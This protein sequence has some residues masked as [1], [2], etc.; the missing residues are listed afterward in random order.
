MRF[1]DLN[2]HPLLLNTI[3]Q[4]GYLM[5]TP[6]Q[7]R[8]I[9]EVLK[10]R[11]LLACA[12]TGTG[13]TAAFA[14]PILHRLLQHPRK[15]HLPRVLVLAPTRELATQIIESFALYG[16]G[17]GLSG[18]VIFGG[19]S[20]G[21]QIRALQEGIDVL[22]AAPG[23]L[24]DLMD[25][26]YVK[27]SNIE[28]FVLDEADRM[29]DMGFIK[30]IKR[31]LAV[32]PPKRQNLLF[33]ATMPAEIRE[34]TKRLLN[35]PIHIAVTPVASTVDR[36]D[37]RVYFVAKARKTDLL[38]HV[39]TDR[40]ADRVIVFTRTKHGANRLS[41]KLQKMLINAEAIHGDKSQNA[42]QKS[43]L[44]FK[45][46]DTR[47]LV[48]T[49]VAARGIDVTG[50]SHVVNF[51][52]P[53]EPESYVHR[54]GRTARA[55]ASGLALSFCDQDEQPLLRN[56]ESLIKT[57]VPV[58]HSH[59]FVEVKQSLCNKKRNAKKRST[60]HYNSKPQYA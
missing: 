39:L 49:D 43:L 20:Q 55:G 11:D 24:L 2:L 38:A 52:L 23:R 33:S 27:L 13:K 14:L 59:P 7:A 6:I 25:Q 57:M 30:P 46:G 12:Q 48:A 35:D 41:G 56:I 45:Q 21:S 36:I 17:S 4:Q 31:V 18:T 22:V 34:L 50:I 3:R 10:G 37:Q 29:L 9:P 15:G 40:S 58:E 5:P 19:V 44:R 51:D 42:R 32:L 47:V 8:A 16:R 28:H 26:G 60:K 53:N 1:D 54:I